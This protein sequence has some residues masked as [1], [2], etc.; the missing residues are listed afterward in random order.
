MFLLP[1][2]E[3]QRLD[4]NPRTTDGFLGLN[5]GQRSVVI[6]KETGKVPR[7]AWTRSGGTLTP[8][9]R[10]PHGVSG[11]GSG[12]WLLAGQAARGTPTHGQCWPVWA[13]HG[14]T[15][16]PPCPPPSARAACS[17]GEAGCEFPVTLSPGL[18]SHLA[19]SWGKARGSS[20]KVGPCSYFVVAG[21]RAAGEGT[22]QAP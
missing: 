22:P 20:R 17:W 1:F 16:G 6:C 4:G 9:H 14:L 7:G 11:R 19:G 18:L 2:G 3:T 10:P 5:L 21:P 15:L 12:L 13:P 8:G